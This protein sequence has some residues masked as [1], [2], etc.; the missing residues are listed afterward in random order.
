MHHATAD[1]EREAMPHRDQL[2]ATALRLTRN[3]ADA[4]DLVQ[5][6]WLRALGAW[7][8]YLPGSNCKAWL[9]RILTNSFINRYRR[10]RR[11][12]HAENDARTDT[13]RGL[14]GSDSDSTAPPQLQ[15]VDDQLGDEV[16]AALDGI[17]D[18]YR[19]VVELADLQGCRYK[20][21]ANDLGVPMGTVMSRLFRARR[22]LEEQLRD[23]AANDYGIVRAA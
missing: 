10:R 1:F 3:P 11:R 6:T 18:D 12:R 22:R 4:E 8:R 14:Y 13:L 21:I 5:E 9:L 7:D 15:L 23:Y 2:Y 19:R 16:S 17:G 20:D